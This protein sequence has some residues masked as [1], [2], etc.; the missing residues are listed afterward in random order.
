MIGY[1]AFDKDLRCFGFQFK[2]GKKYT[3]G[4]KKDE[5]KLC[6][7]TVFHFCRELTAIEMASEYKILTSRICEVIAIGDIINNDVKYGTNKIKI[8]R[9]LSKEEKE[10]YYFNSV[11]WP[12]F[13]EHNAGRNNIGNYNIG[14]YNSGDNNTGNKNVG[15]RNHGNKNIGWYNRGNYNIGE[16][17]LGD[18]NTGYYNIGN[19][20]TGKHNIGHWNIGDWNIGF[21][22]TASQKLYMFNKETYVNAK[23]IK[24]PS[25]LN[26]PTTAWINYED[27]TEEEK[28]KNKRHLD[29]I[30]KRS[31]YLKHLDYKEEFHKAYENASEEEHKML[32]K[33]PNFDVKIFKEISGINV[34]KEYEE[35]QLSKK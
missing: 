11:D 7:N 24:F 16:N 8:L 18:S 31:G 25:F 27:M 21:F 32:F 34:S 23:N 12:N 13:G 1:K 22:N 4:F 5:L 2:V 28:H 3:T 14:D 15:C 33:L 30:K 35:Y 9:E 10:K 17:N 19:N 29:E 26:F 6:S 20:N